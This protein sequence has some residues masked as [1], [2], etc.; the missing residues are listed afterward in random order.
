[1]IDGLTSILDKPILMIRSI[2]EAPGKT[3]MALSI[4]HLE[5]EY[6]LRDIFQTTVEAYDPQAKLKQFG[7]SDSLMAYL[8][9]A[10]EPI[11]L[12]V[13]DIRVPGSLNGIGV[14]KTL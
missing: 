8:S 4:V 9:A 3:T 7:D 2:G 12:I 6:L 1:M 14:V 5:D 13:V 11:D 10:T